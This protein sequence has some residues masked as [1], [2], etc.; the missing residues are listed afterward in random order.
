MVYAWPWCA[1]KPSIAACAN[2][3]GVLA[4]KAGN[5]RI[6]RLALHQG[7]QHPF[8]AFAGHRVAFPVANAC[9]RFNYGWACCNGQVKPETFSGSFP[10]K[11]PFI[12][13][14]GLITVFE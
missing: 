11:I 8:P 5:H 2:K 12:L 7:E 6:Q 9:A 4:V 14:R 13:Q 10:I 3:F 1:R